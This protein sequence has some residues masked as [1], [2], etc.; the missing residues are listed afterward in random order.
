MFTH[1]ANDSQKWQLISESVSSLKT[2]FKT[3][4]LFGGTTL[5]DPDAIKLE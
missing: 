1:A 5:H 2:I 3:D 4:I